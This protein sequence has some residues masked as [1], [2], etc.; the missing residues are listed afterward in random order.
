MG[1][2]CSPARIFPDFGPAERRSNM[3]NKR[4]LPVI[5]RKESCKLAV[6]DICY[7]YRTN[8]KLQFETDLGVKT[9]YKK[10]ADIEKNLG[11]EFYRCTS[12]CI[13][14]LTRIGDMKEGIVYFDDG[15]TIKLGKESF[16]RLKQKFNAYLLGFIPSDDSNNED[17][18]ESE[19]NE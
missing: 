4:Y 2:P 16:L 1:I 14:N 12:G 5:S 9:T 15:K 11:P 6:S 13:V 10:I 3:D 7:V 8:R 17:S 19:E 18:E